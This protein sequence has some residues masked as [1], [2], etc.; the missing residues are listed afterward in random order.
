MIAR[1]LLAALALFATP[2][3]ASAQTGGIQ[4][5]PVLVSLSPERAMGSVSLR[6]GRHRA[7]SFEVEAYAWTQVNGEDQLVR[8]NDLIV[9][10]SVFE[11][12]ANGEQTIRLG[13]RNAS[14]DGGEQA[15]RILLRELPSDQQHG[16][17]LG[18]TLEMSLP[19]F[20]TPRGAVAIVTD[21]VDG[22]HIILS[23][24]GASFA[25]INLMQS[26]ERLPSPRYLL[27]GSSAAIELPAQTNGIQLIVSGAGGLHHE[28]TINVGLPDH[29]AS[30]R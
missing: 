17:A 24:E 4:V 3:L 25:Q 9:A 8:T 29:L 19:V 20:M 30:V 18:F 5:A 11:V 26:D 14:R 16:V 15:Y 28:R 23:N 21:R 7:V 13:V 2:G 12:V 10:P 1:A 22:Q 27:A 6:N